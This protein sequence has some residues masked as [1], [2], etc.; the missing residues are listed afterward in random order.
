MITKGKKGSYAVTVTEDLTAKKMNSGDLE[1]FATPAMVAA[2]EAAAVEAVADM[3]EPE[4]TTVGC[5]ISINHNAPTLLDGKVVAEA[6]LTDVDGRVL[7]FSVKASDENGI[8][9]EGEHTRVIVAREK[10]L[11][12]AKNRGE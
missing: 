12:K 3:I 5:D 6:E 8:I 2:M 1:V 11:K 7:T 4:N 9:G 10:F